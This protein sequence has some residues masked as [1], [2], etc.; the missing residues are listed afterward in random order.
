MR[1]LTIRQREALDR[2]LATKFPRQDCREVTGNAMLVGVVVLVFAIA[3][4]VL[5]FGGPR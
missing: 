3:A 4:G 5:I 1:A 2:L